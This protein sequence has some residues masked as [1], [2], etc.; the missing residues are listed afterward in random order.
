M[1]RRVLLNR[2]LVLEDPVLQ[3]DGAGGRST[4][5]TPLGMLWAEIRPKSGG[6]LYAGGAERAR[7]GYRLVVRAAPVGSQQRPRAAQRLREGSRYFDILAVAD[8][9]TDGKYLEIHAQEGIRP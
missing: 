9:G 4:V 1:T 2:R 5:W 7:V 3:P 8:F 6:E